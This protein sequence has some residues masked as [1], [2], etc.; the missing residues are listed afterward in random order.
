[1][2]R[3]KRTIRY[4]DDVWALLE[5]RTK[6][7]GRPVTAIVN[8]CVRQQLGQTEPNIETRLNALEARVSAIE[9]RL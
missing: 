8:D 3:E 7:T 6:A 4:D 5:A 1:M 2:V 9:D